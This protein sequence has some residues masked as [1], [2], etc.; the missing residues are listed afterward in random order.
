MRVGG[1]R[2]APAAFAPGRDPVPTA[3]EAGWATGRGWTGAENVAQTG[4]RTPDRPSH[5]ESL[6]RLRHAQYCRLLATAKLIHIA[7]M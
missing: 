6:Y 5:S 7:L 2:H 4:I 1:Q 3:Q